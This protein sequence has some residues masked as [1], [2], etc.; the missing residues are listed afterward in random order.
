MGEFWATRTGRWRKMLQAQSAP[1]L[2]ER[3]YAVIRSDIAAGSLPVGALLP[4][5]ERVA[6]ELVVN[7]T[8]VRAAYARL[9]A[10]GDIAR[11]RDDELYIRGP[12]GDADASVGD[13]TQIR[14]ESALLKAV[15]EAAAR[16]MSH[17]DGQVVYINEKARSGSK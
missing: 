9:L 13:A 10:E 16:G 3:L 7:V 1:S 12:G 4:S 2:G 8:D 6:Q 14:F 17:G 11:R 5:A 15:R